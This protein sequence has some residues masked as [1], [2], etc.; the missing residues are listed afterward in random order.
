[1]KHSLKKTTSLVLVTL[2]TLCCLNLY[3]YFESRH[4]AE[5]HE[6]QVAHTHKVIL[7]ATNF[8]SHM[9]D[10]E[11]GQRGFLLTLEEGYLT[12]YY[13]GVELSN[14]ALAQLRLLTRDNP[15][16]QVKLSRLQSYSRSKLEEL[17]L[18]IEYAKSGNM[19]YAMDTVRGGFGKATMDDIRALIE[20]FI[21]EEERL[22]RLQI[23]LHTSAKDATQTELTIAL[24]LLIFVTLFSAIRFRSRFIIPVLELTENTEKFAQDKSKAIEAK[25]YDNEIGTLAGTF[26]DMSQEIIQTIAEL[27]YAKQKSEDSSLAKSR[28]LFNMSDEVRSPLNGIYGTLQL[29]Q[30]GKYS[31]DSE[32]IS[33]LEKA[34]YSC[35]ALQAIINDIIDYAKLEAGRLGVENSTF[36][37]LRIVHMTLARMSPHAKDKGLALEVEIEKGLHEHWVGDAARIKQILMNLI[38]NCIK[39]THR[40]TLHLAVYAQPTDGQL[41]FHIKDSNINTSDVDKKKILEDYQPIKPL[42]ATQLAEFG[43]GMA[44]TV[45]LVD[46]M[47]SEIRIINHSDQGLEYVIVLPLEQ[48]ATFETQ[49]DVEQDSALPNWQNLKIAVIED[50]EVNLLIC[51]GMLEKTGCQVITAT[52]GKEGSRLVIKEQPD[53]VLMDIHMPVM[54]GIEAHK[55]IKAKCPRIPVIALTAKVMDADTQTYQEEGFQG[56][57]A[58]PVEMFDLYQEVSRHLNK[59]SSHYRHMP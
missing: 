52:N 18:T 35:K 29:I 25:A 57:L 32:F 46:L 5:F 14:Q 37:T 27:E 49:I 23:D 3:L 39:C 58:K 17:A 31:S 34:L 10:A 44:I 28:L 38:S 33:Q 30:R 20:E 7:T 2:I 47:D 11:T 26:S 21:Q 8:Y 19:K 43:L 16:Q 15:D 59:P 55:L 53:L 54:D 36:S 50:S 6:K 9:K 40:R 42:T 45:A 12:P 22:L 51:K 48:A 41:T 13:Q 24:I 4:T 1:M 56:C